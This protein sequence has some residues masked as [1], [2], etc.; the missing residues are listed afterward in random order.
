MSN[1]AAVAADAH[2][3]FCLASSTTSLDF[4]S[5]SAAQPQPGGSP[6]VRINP[7]SGAIQKIYSPVLATVQ[8][9]AVDPG[10]PQTLYATAA[11]GLLRSTDGG[12]T[13][14]ALPGFPSDTYLNAVAVDPTNGNI[15][16]AGTTTVGALKSTGGGVT[17]TAIRNVRPYVV[18]DQPVAVFADGF[19]VSG[20]AAVMKPVPGLPGDVYEISVYTPDLATLFG[21]N[22]DNHNPVIPPEVP[23]KPFIGSTQSQQGLWCG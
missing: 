10:N 11:A 15:V 17:W 20:I 13:W 21:A 5:V 18:T 23:I 22:P 4:P 8:S 12:N 14:K 6:L 2:G 9:N 1:V 16:Y 19:Y 7:S 3:N